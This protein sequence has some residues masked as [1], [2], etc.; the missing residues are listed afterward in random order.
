MRQRI[1][2]TLQEVATN[3][4]TVLNSMETAGKLNKEIG[5]GASEPGAGSVTIVFK[6][7]VDPLE[8]AGGGFTRAASRAGVKASAADPKMPKRRPEVSLEG[9]PP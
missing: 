4:R 3:R 7:N 8:A 6:S 5:L 9:A 1:T 2:K